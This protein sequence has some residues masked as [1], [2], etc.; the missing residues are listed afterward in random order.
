M[1][2]KS[3]NIQK[4]QSLRHYNNI[5]GAFFSLLKVMTYYKSIT[6]N[7]T[8]K[9]KCRFQFKK[10]YLAFRFLTSKKLYFKKHANI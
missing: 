4:Y 6:L 1:N 9:D 7:K 5:K 3:Q 2:I 8:Y 10:Y